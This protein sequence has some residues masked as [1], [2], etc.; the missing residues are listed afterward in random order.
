VTQIHVRGESGAVMYFDRAALPEGIQSRINRGDL[1][2]VNPDGSPWDD[3]TP[4]ITDEQPP[5]G[6]PALPD[7]RANRAAWVEFG[8]EQGMDR[9]EANSLTKQQL[10]KEFTGRRAVTQPA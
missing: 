10:I 4:E 3:S 8:V 1:V 7:A 5:D 9:T 2:R 6:A